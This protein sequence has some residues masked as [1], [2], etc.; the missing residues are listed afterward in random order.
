MFISKKILRAEAFLGNLTDLPK[1]KLDLMKLNNISIQLC[2]FGI[3]F[4]KEGNIWKTKIFQ[5]PKKWT[6]YRIPHIWI[7][8]QSFTEY[9]RLTLVFMRNS[10]LQEK[11]NFCFF[12]RFLLV[13]TKFSFWQ[14]DW[15]LGYYSMKF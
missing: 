14:G 5:K 15:A 2:K 8:L 12:K 4:S 3:N 1:Q 11:F 13:L 6:S 7:S 9:L 10:A